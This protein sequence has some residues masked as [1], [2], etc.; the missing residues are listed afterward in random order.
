MQSLGDRSLHEQNI[1][2]C[3]NVLWHGFPKKNVSQ[4]QWG[5]CDIGREG[6]MQ[7]VGKNHQELHVHTGIWCAQ[8]SNSEPRR[9]RRHFDWSGWD[10][11]YFQIILIKENRI[12]VSLLGWVFLCSP[13]H[14]NPSSASRYLR[15]GSQF[16]SVPSWLW[17][18]SLLCHKGF[19]FPGLFFT[20]CI[21]L[22]LYV[23]VDL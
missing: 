13:V 1:S 15:V 21:Y 7:C 2:Y 9:S 12:S 3:I 11:V 19:P 8:S 17:W 10:M 20:L 4:M 23:E 16:S 18:W 14:F 5:N 22:S 6:H